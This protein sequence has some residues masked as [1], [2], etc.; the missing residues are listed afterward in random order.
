MLKKEEIL[1]AF[2][3]TFFLGLILFAICF[4]TFS[5]PLTKSL[6]EQERIQRRCEYYMKL[7]RYQ[8]IHYLRL[9]DIDE[10]R[11]CQEYY[12]NYAKRK[13]NYNK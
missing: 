3:S 2:I 10:I 4:I 11:F 1:I 13:E 5:P 7:Y 9:Q 6:T 12:K 8:P